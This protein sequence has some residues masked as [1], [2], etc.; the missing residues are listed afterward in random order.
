MKFKSD[1]DIDFGDRNQILSLLKHTPASIIRNEK[2]TKH[3]TGV[4][5]TDIPVDPY[6]GQASLDY[7]LALGS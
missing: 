5:F 6:T 7:Q 3:N 4:Y 1:I 2:L